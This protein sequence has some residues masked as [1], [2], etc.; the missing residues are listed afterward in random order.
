MNEAILMNQESIVK[1]ELFSDFICP[2]CFIG[3]SRMGRLQN[4]LSDISVLIHLKPYLLYPMIPLDGVDK[5]AFANKSRPGTGRGL[6]HECQI[7]N[8]SINYQLIDKIPSSR[9][10]H[11]LI[12]TIDD[13]DLQFELAQSIFNA[14]FT[15][16]ENIGSKQVLVEIAKDY[17][18]SDDILKSFMHS[19]FGQ[20]EVDQNLDDARQDQISLVPTLRLNDQFVIP[21][22]QPLEVWEK[23]IR[24]AHRLQLNMGS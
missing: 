12:Q 22:L 1:V 16:G 17:K 9:E 3:K 8:L 14:Y 21:G 10:A 4:R 5:T 24:R 20:K 15:Y 18:I 6:K 11:R 23:Y 2:W 19:N 13:T 7:E